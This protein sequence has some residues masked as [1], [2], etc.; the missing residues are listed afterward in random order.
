M[1]LGRSTDKLFTEMKKIHNGKHVCEAGRPGKLT[2]A[3]GGTESRQEPYGFVLKIKKALLKNLQE[4][5]RKQTSYF[6]P[7]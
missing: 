7:L 3:D 2:K 1:S 6:S 5:K 4:D